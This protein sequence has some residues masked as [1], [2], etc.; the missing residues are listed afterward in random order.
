M[1]SQYQR[2]SAHLLTGSL[3]FNRRLQ[4]YIATQAAVRESFYAQYN[5]P[6]FNTFGQR[7]MPNAGGPPTQT[8]NHFMNQPMLPPQGFTQV[9]PSFNQSSQSSNPHTFRSAPYS[10]ADRPPGRSQP[11]QRSASLSTPQ[12]MQSY[13]QP[14]AFVNGVV[15]VSQSEEQRRMSLPPQP[16]EH[17]S[18]KMEQPPSRPSLS[19]STSQSVNNEKMSALQMS[20]QH[21]NSGTPRSPLSTQSTPA[22]QTGATPG[23]TAPVGVVGA[24]YAD[25]FFQNN[26]FFS[27]SMPPETQQLIA[28]GLKPSDPMA[29]TFMQGSEHIALPIPKYTYNPNIS[30]KPSHEATSNSMS[31]V[32]SNGVSKV[33]N[34]MP[35]NPYVPLTMGQEQPNK[36]DNLDSF[37]LINPTSET[38]NELFPST[39][40]FDFGMFSADQPI[41]N[42]N[43]DDLFNFDQQ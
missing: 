20:P 42:D 25:S 30:P 12:E 18:I 43:F 41:S 26:N 14:T 13:Q 16:L 38:S 11:H 3:N 19:R 8:M 5:Q 34:I 33:E 7:F 10:I 9:S 37:S 32:P 21:S 22:L 31:K 40:F 15:G 28:P 35:S 6:P 27:L 2:L 4:D 36:M 23:S 17:L 24:P 1:P 29:A 39:D